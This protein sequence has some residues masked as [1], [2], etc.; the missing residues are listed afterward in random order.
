[1]SFQAAE[2]CRQREESSRTTKEENGEGSAASHE[3]GAKQNRCEAFLTQAGSSCPSA[4]GRCPGQQPTRQAFVWTGAYTF[5]IQTHCLIL[6][7]LL[8]HP[9]RQDSPT[10]P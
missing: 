3:E 2:N 1:M 10:I 5:R 7:C 6:M 9:G 8:S 4:S